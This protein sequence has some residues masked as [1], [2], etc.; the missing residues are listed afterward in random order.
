MQPKVSY[1]RLTLQYGVDNDSGRE[2]LRTC[3]LSTGPYSNRGRSLHT[4]QFHQI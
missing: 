3:A 1:D 2:G 4:F